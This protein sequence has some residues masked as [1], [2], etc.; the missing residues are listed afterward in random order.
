MCEGCLLIGLPETVKAG[1]KRR[2]WTFAVNR[3]KAGK[4]E[5]VI[6][7]E[8]VTKNGEP[9]WKGVELLRFDED[10]RREFR[11]MYYAR[12]DKDKKWA[13]GQFCPMF[14]PEM[15]TD[16]IQEMKRQGWIEL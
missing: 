9:Y 4:I 5:H 10:N 1:Y 12:R 8:Q 14:P 11:F 2:G 15:L 16:V 7:R 3:K 13:W 6:L